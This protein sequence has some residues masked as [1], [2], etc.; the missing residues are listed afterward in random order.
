MEVNQTYF[1]I[2][3]VA[4]KSPGHAMRIRLSAAGHKLART[5]ATLTLP[6]TCGIL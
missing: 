1:K 5:C 2:K 3:D 6:V 4:Q